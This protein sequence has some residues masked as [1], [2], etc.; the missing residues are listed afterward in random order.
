M[1]RVLS[2]SSQ[3]EGWILAAIW[4]WVKR[5]S[6]GER[7]FWEHLCFPWIGFWES[8]SLTHRH[9]KPLQAWHWPGG[10]ATTQ[11]DI[12]LK[13]ISDLSKVC[14]GRETQISPLGLPRALL[15]TRGESDR[16]AFGRVSRGFNSTTKNTW[17]SLLGSTG[18]PVKSNMFCLSGL[19]WFVQ[20]RLKTSCFWYF[21]HSQLSWQKWTK[22]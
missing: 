17:V 13:P 11:A 16:E 3:N 10:S 22:I 4:L 9:L 21:H 8:P 19:T 12:Q 15:E 7:S 2:F 20:L 14:S 5:R 6:L 18:R 1:Q